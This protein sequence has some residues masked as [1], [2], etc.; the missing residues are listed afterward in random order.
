MK[1]DNIETDFAIIIR[2]M[3]YLGCIYAALIMKN[4]ILA[5]MHFE[6]LKITQLEMGIFLELI[7]QIQLCYLFLY[8]L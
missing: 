2:A 1:F 5:G 3:S 8:K 6:K 7:L 4:Y